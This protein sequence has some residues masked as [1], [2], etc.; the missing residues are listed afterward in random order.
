MKSPGEDPA[1]AKAAID[2]SIKVREEAV[3]TSGGAIPGKVDQLNDIHLYNF[4]EALHTVED[5]T[6]PAHTDANG[7]P[8]DWNGLPTSTADKDQI[9]QHMREEANITADQMNA[10]VDAAHQ[11]FKDTFGPE[12]E[13]QA[14]QP[15]KT[16]RLKKE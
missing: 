1:A 10:A 11:A 9:D 6:S 12:L 14:E 2:Q 8:R 3:K 15:P 16:D 13:K 7:N 4:G 5:R